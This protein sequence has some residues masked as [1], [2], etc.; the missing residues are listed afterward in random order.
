VLH[1][2]SEDSKLILGSGV[3]R[4]I[5][6]ATKL[7]SVQ[8]YAVSTTAQQADVV[9]A[10]SALPDLQQLTW[11]EVACGQQG[12]LS[13]SRLLQHLTRLTGLELGSVAAE[14]LQHLSVLTKLQHLSMPSP[15]AWA[16]AD[17]PG[18]QELQGLTCLVLSVRLWAKRQR[19]PAC[20]THLT[21]LQQLGVLCAT[22]PELNR[23]TALN[24]LTKLR[25]ASLRPSSTALQLPAL[26]FL[27]LQGNLDGPVRL[28]LHSSHLTSCTQCVWFSCCRRQPAL[29]PM[30]LPGCCMPA[31]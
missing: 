11:R 26:Q 2:V 21:A 4:D 17:Y 16:A 5:A 18:L 29:P 6:A 30:C 1:G 19:F 7:S 31:T 24:A 27:N 22:Y 14:A 13:D 25:V 12:E 3:W 20:V 10:L 9:S 8:L 28:L 15:H 23:L